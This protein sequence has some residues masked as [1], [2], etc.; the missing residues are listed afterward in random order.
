MKT[1]LPA[2]RVFH[3]DTGRTIHKRGMANRKTLFSIAFHF[4]RLIFQSRK[5]NSPPQKMTL[6]G[7][8]IKASAQKSPDRQNAVFR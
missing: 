3:A 6:D 8:V 7:C 2:M 4:S 1:G 5:R